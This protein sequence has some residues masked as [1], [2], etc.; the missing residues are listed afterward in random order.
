MAAEGVSFTHSTAGVTVTSGEGSAALGSGDVLAV[1]AALASGAD[2]TIAFAVPCDG[3]VR[4]DRP[5][6][7]MMR[8]RVAE[9]RAL[10]TADAVP[11]AVE[12]ARVLGF[13][14]EQVLT[15]RDAPQSRRLVADK[16]AWVHTHDGVG[17]LVS[18][19]DE[20]VL[21]VFHAEDADRR[22]PPVRSWGKRSAG[23]GGSAGHGFPET[24]DELLDRARRFGL[25]CELRRGSGHWHISDAEGR[26]CTTPATPSD[27][28]SLRNSVMRIRTELGVDL[29]TLHGQVIGPVGSDQAYC[30][31]LGSRIFLARRAGRL[32]ADRAAGVAYRWLNGAEWIGV[33]SSSVD[34]IDAAADR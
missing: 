29:R 31:A 20:A 16:S 24:V 28:R 3:G 22:Y 11:A 4:E 27:V 13:S 19:R 1:I 21:S 6:P 10:T 8:P 26:S 5:K 34:A 23:S 7:S 17:A 12:W 14:R 9:R 25:Q 2:H 32:L 30:A 33:H 15:A 18:D